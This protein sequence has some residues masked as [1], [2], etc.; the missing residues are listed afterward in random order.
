M[1]NEGK[2][3]TLKGDNTYLKKVKNLL[4]IIASNYSINDNELNFTLEMNLQNQQIR[5]LLEKCLNCIGCGVCTVLCPVNALYLDDSKTIN[6][7]KDLCVGC[8]ACCKNIDSKLK[9]G[10]IA[11]NYKKE[12]LSIVF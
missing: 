2:C 5:L 3:Y 11:R 4:F 12:R 1:N 7:N 9:M 6:V 8:L 10:C